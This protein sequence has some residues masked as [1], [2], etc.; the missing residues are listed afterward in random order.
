MV[1]SLSRIMNEIQLIPF[2]KQNDFYVVKQDAYL[3]IHQ[4]ILS[5]VEDNL[6]DELEQ[7]EGDYNDM[8]RDVYTQLHEDIEHFKDELF[9]VK[10]S[11]S[12]IRQYQ[13]KNQIIGDVEVYIDLKESLKLALI[14]A[15]LLGNTYHRPTA[16]TTTAKKGSRQVLNHR[17]PFADVTIKN[18]QYLYN[19]G[20]SYKTLSFMTGHTLTKQVNED[21]EEVLLL[22]PGFKISKSEDR[23]SVYAGGTIVMDDTITTKIEDDDSDE[24]LVYI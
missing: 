5:I 14:P 15:A 13:Q 18:Q 2:Y 20:E 19:D 22:Q 7:H 4:K 16:I 21:D 1:K 11:E 9:D 8:V 23:L 24:E 6:N 12:E 10:I 17:N 3:D